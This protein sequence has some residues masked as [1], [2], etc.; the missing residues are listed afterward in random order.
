MYVFRLKNVL[1]IY[2]L[3][4]LFLISCN[5]QNDVVNQT[6]EENPTFLEEKVF[7]LGDISDDPGEVIE[8]TQPLADYLANQLTEYGYTAGQVKI[9]ASMDEM[10]GY[11]Q[12]GEIDLYFDSVYPATIVSDASGAQIIL[13]RWRFGV[14]EYQSVI[15][16]RN[17]SGI[18]TID[19]LAGHMIAFDAP[20]STSGFLMPGTHLMS[21]GLN[22]VGKASY[23]EMIGENEVGF[24][25]SYDDENT[26]QWV[27]RGFVAAGATDDW[28][29]DL[30]FPE[31]VSSQ[32]IELARTEYLPR[33]VVVANPHIDSEVLEFIKLI[34]T[35]AHETEAG[36]LALEPFQTT[37]F[38]EFPEGIE[39]TINRMRDLRDIIANVP[40]P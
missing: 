33:Q 15:F 6:N 27:L 22:M 12:N 31:D 39:S 17:D 24:V 36:A 3:I 7:V 18:E 37:R 13:R 28:H 34:L 29:F 16:T 5:L 14:D 19:D 23:H 1:P 4:P 30:S 21:N 25:F 11:L 26:V 40:L 8:G 9:A 2:L 38:D 32:L 10:I 35:H 20:Y